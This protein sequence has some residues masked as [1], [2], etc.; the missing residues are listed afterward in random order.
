MLR[1]LAAARSNAL[2]NFL[3]DSLAEFRIVAAGFGAES[4]VVGDDIGRLAALNHAD[5]A[6]AGVPSFYDQ[7]VPAVLH[8]VGDRQRRDRDRADAL[9]RVLAGVAGE[10]VECRSSSGSRPSRRS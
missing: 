6:R 2:S 8:Q 3:D 4:H 5:V 9:G 10:A 7:P 1:T